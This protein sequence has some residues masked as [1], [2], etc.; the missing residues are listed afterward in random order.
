MA[1]RM[2]R[3]THGLLRQI[4]RLSVVAAAQ[5]SCAC[6]RPHPARFPSWEPTSALV[7]AIRDRARARRYL[8]ESRSIWERTD[9]IRWS[10]GGPDGTHHRQRPRREDERKPRSRYTYVR[11]MELGDHQVLFTVLVVDRGRV[12]SRSLIEADPD[13]LQFNSS[14]R[15]PES[16]RVRWHENN[17]EVGRHTDGAP[18][19]TIDA[20]YG[21][22][23]DD[24]LATHPE[25]AVHL[26]FHPDGVLQHCGFLPD[27]CADCPTVSIQS[28]VESHHDP[29][30]AVSPLDALCSDRYG[31]F[32]AGAYAL[33]DWKCLCESRLRPSRR[34]TRETGEP[35]SICEIDPAACPRSN[36]RGPS[37]SC[38]T[39]GFC[40]PWPQRPTVPREVGKPDP[41]GPWPVD[42]RRGSH[43]SGSCGI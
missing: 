7:P 19:V 6:A 5:L 17:A 12:A 8:A 13:R 30:A 43:R 40:G 39:L 23:R 41:T 25:L 2:S 14:S 16:L 3:R 37:W 1:L 24:V 10:W 15:D 32:P 42:W 33:F 34:Q 4:R 21:S 29:A 18:A 31:L 36:D 22:C 9:P 38:K 28:Y 20:L 26:Y 27:E 11:A 35:G